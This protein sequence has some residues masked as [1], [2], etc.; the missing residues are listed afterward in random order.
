LTIFVLGQL[1]QAYIDGAPR[2]TAAA[3][4]AAYGT[5]ANAPDTGRNISFAVH[6]TLAEL[7]TLGLAE[8]N[9][10][11][12]DF[13]EGMPWSCGDDWHPSNQNGGGNR[14]LPPAIGNGE[15]NGDFGGGILEVLADP[16]LFS[17]DRP[18]F[19]RVLADAVGGGAER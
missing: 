13:L 11:L 19:D 2:P 3:I 15:N 1:R 8:A 9:F 4:A 5:Y 12:E 10:P 7:Q 17:L 6:R 16:M 14:P 18:D